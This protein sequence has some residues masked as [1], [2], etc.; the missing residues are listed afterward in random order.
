MAGPVKFE[1]V[2]KAELPSARHGAKSPGPLTLAL[3]RGDIVFVAGGSARATS[4][5]L[6][7]QGLRVRNRRG[8]RNGVQGVYVWAEKNGTGV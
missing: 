1:V 6:T 8:E 7:A 3:L 2:P 4:K 5:S